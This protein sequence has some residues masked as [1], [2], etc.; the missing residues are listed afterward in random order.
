MS[1]N[2]NQFAKKKIILILNMKKITFWYT[3]KKTSSTFLKTHELS[4]KL[5]QISLSNWHLFVF[6]LQYWLMLFQLQI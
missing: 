4:R 1:V 5:K 3:F 6:F 2:L